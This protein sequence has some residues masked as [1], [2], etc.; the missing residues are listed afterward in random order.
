[1]YLRWL[2]GSRFFLLGV[3]ESFSVRQA[4]LTKAFTKPLSTQDR[5]TL[6]TQQAEEIINIDRGKLH[7]LYND[8]ACLDITATFHHADL[9]LDLENSPDA[10]IPSPNNWKSQTE[11]FLQQVFGYPYG[12]PTVAEL[13]MSAAY[14]AA[15]RSVQLGRSVGAAIVSPHGQ[16]LSTGWNEVPVPGGGVADH[17][18][19]PHLREH[20]GT[21]AVDPADARKLDAIRDFLAALFVQNSPDFTRQPGEPESAGVE[22]FN[23]ARRQLSDA[24]PTSVTM[25]WLDSLRTATSHIGSPTIDDIKPLALVPAVRKTRLFNLIEFGATVHAE[26]AAI[27]GAARHGIAIQGQ[28]MYVTTFPC[29]E[30]ARNIVA[31]GISRVVYIEPYSKSLAWSLYP[32]QILF[33]SAD[34]KGSSGSRQNDL[35]VFEQF[36]GIS[37]SR[38]AELFSPVK[39]KDDLERCAIDKNLDPGAVSG[40]RQASANLRNSI[41]SRGA[42]PRG[43]SWIIRQSME[44][45][46]MALL[47]LRELW[48]EA[49]RSRS[50]DTG[51]P[52][53]PSPSVPDNEG[54]ARPASE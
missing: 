20:K 7:T 11:R 13:G 29:H 27:T 44:L 25:D 54:G 19:S 15:R 9:F 52:G 50:I 39:R 3:Y 36:T 53:N 28:A 17:N 24:K 48:D 1:D 21:P 46:A 32:Q 38:H 18:N 5:E 23:N 14:A 34:T 4:R 22:E 26:M 41:V 51:Q 2:Y 31:A 10:K 35:V 49:L 37:P 47:D 8:E 12:S 6:A 30:C 45:E 42:A 33:L 16:I 43:P 40:F